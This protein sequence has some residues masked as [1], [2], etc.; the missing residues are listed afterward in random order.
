MNNKE[1]R[2]S[3]N[4]YSKWHRK[5]PDNC[6]MVDI[7]SIEIRNNG[8]IAIIETTE[9]NYAAAIPKYIHSIINGRAK[10]QIEFIKNLAISLK[11]SAYYVFHDKDCSVFYIYNVLDKS[12]TKYDEKQ[13]IIFIKNLKKTKEICRG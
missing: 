8:P 7:D 4:N 10:F 5:L 3:G 1:E 11:I 6:I 9:F 13:Y 12:I 2:V